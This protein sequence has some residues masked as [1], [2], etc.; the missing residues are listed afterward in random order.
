MYVCTENPA[1]KIFVYNINDS[2]FNYLMIYYVM[3]YLFIY[4]LC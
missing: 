3:F 1:P 4:L 2:L